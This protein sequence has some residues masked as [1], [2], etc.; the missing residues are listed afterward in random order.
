MIQDVEVDVPVRTAYNQWT[1]FEDFPLFMDH[2]EWV[3]QLTED[4]LRWR[5]KIAGVSREWEAH[6]VEQTPDQRIEWV[7]TD[8]TQ[9]TGAVTFHTLSPD[10]TRIVLQ[11]DM[12]PEGLLETV[13]DKGGFVSDR[14]RKDLDAFK[15]FIENRGFET[16]AYRGEIHDGDV[17]EPAIDLAGREHQESHDLRG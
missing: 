12:D 8:G 15:A 3:R 11:L 13:A 6:I 14:A 4:T 7:A 16:G 9:N 1:Q 2:V 5:A 10:R 17:I